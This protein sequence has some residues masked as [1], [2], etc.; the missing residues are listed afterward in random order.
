[1]L[2]EVCVN[3]A[4][5]RCVVLLHFHNTAEVKGSETLWCRTSAAGVT[6]RRIMFLGLS[7]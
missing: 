7:L 6:F 5:A 2:V 4:N 3:W 1:M